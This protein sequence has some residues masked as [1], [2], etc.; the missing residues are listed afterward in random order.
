MNKVFQHHMDSKIF[1]NN[2]KSGPVTLTTVITKLTLSTPL[3]TFNQHLTDILVNWESNNI[4]R[5]PIDCQ[6]SIATCTCESVDALLTVNQLL[7]QYQ[8]SMI[9]Q[10]RCW[11]SADRYVSQ[12]LMEG[13]KYT[14]SKTSNLWCGLNLY[15]ILFFSLVVFFI[16]TFV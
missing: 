7:I 2:T 14:S 5:H 3:L 10:W 1:C 12:V 11:S 8:L 9:Y 4:C 6:M 16:C 15:S 13:K